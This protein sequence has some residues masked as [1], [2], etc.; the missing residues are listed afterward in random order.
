MNE[1][2]TKAIIRRTGWQDT[3]ECWHRLPNKVFFFALLAAWVVLFQ[4][5]G[6]SILGYIHTSSLFAWLY[7]AY[8][9]GGEAGEDASIG[10]LIPFLVVGNFLVETEGT[11]RAAAANMVAGNFNAGSGADVAHG[12]LCRAAAAPFSRRTVR[13]NLRVDGAG[14]GT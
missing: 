8:N 12:G 6:N 10:N 1:N 7:N 2:Q 4:F 5:L 11:A 14:L 9:I 3:I 13:G